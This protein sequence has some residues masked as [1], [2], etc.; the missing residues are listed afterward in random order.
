MNKKALQ[1]LLS[2]I[3]V[4]GFLI[5]ILYVTY[6]FNGF[7]TTQEHKLKYYPEL[8]GFF[9]D[10]D[11]ITNNHFDSIAFFGVIF[12][13]ILLIRTIYMINSLFNFRYDNDATFISLLVSNIICVFFYYIFVNLIIDAVIMDNVLVSILMMLTF[14]GYG[15]IVIYEIAGYDSR[16]G[17]FGLKESLDVFFRETNQYNNKKEEL[18]YNYKKMIK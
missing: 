8:L 3:K 9:N 14:A 11:M 4:F 2:I 12:G 15:T 5:P 6:L 16:S 10:S 13:I 18:M 17:A 7:E 1:V